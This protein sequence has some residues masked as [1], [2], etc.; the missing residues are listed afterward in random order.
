MWHLFKHTEISC[1]CRKLSLSRPRGDKGRSPS[2]LPHRIDV[3][4][5]LI[6]HLPRGITGILQGWC[7]SLTPRVLEPPPAL[8]KL[9]VASRRRCFHIQSQEVSF[10]SGASLC[11][12]Y[13]TI[14]GKQ[15]RTSFHHKCMTL[16]KKI[17]GSSK[18]LERSQ[19]E[20]R[21]CHPKICHP[22]VRIILSWRLL[23][24]WNPL[25]A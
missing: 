14:I 9:V 3:S 17:R 16:K 6:K 25:S 12:C 23:S 22:G 21:I 13:E 24:S 11:N 18:K 8:S 15:D 1:E 2:L 4:C 19:Q 20:A 10:I 5:L 7:L